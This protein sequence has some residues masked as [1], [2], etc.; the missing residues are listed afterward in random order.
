MSVAP[1]QLLIAPLRA[2]V[3]L[4][5]LVAMTPPAPAQGPIRPPLPTPAPAAEPPTAAE[6]SA[7]IAALDA[8]A[9]LDE[10]ARTT[11]K[12][13]YTDAI[14]ELARAEEHAARAKAFAAAASEAP[15]LLETIRAE[16]AQPPPDAAPAAPEGATLAQLEQALAQASAD[17]AAARQREQE[18][19]A[20]VDRAATRRSTLP[21]QIA[22]AR[23]RLADLDA[24][25][26]A[27]A[28]PAAAEPDRARRALLLAQRHAAAREIEA[29]GAELAREDAQRDLVPARRD[30]A[31]RRSAQAEK[32]HGAWQVIVDRTRQAEAE[33]A[34]REAERQRR[35]DAARRH[36]ALAALA[37]SN[38]DLAAARSGPGGITAKISAA[39]AELRDTI[40]RLDTI[41]AQFKSIRRR[42][43]VTGV[44]AATGRV[45]QRQRASLPDPDGL[46]RREREL[47]DEASDASLRLFELDERRVGAGD[48]D[49]RVQEILAAVPPNQRDDAEPIARELVTAQRDLLDQSG[50][51][52]ATYVD[53]LEQLTGKTRQLSELTRDFKAAIEERILWVRSV[54]GSIGDGV[55]ATPA[56]VR[57]LL[58]PD[59]WR[60]ALASAREEIERRPRAIFGAVLI[61]CVAAAGIWSRRE[62]KRLAEMA[63]RVRT[64]SV[65]QALAALVHSVIIALP[66]PLALGA[67]GWVL[68]QPARQPDVAIAVGHALR[69]AARI[70]FPLMVIHTVLRPGGLCRAHLGWPEAGAALNRR[71]L[72]WFMAVI[73]PLAVIVVAMDRQDVSGLWSDGLGRMAFTAAMLAFAAFAALTLHPARPL[74]GHFMVHERGTWRYRLDRL[75]IGL[76][77]GSPIALVILSWLGYYYTAL[78]LERRLQWSI[79]L[80]V[81]VVL[82]YGILLR[83][84]FLARRRLAIEEARRR[85]ES[86]RAASPA[87]PGEVAELPPIEEER[88]DI[89]AIDSQTRRLLRLAVAATALIGVLSIWSEIA[90]ALRVLDRV[91]IW[92]RLAFT[93]LTEEAP[94]SLAPSGSAEGGTAA[95]PSPSPEAPAPAAGEVPLPSTLAGGATGDPDRAGGAATIVSLADVGLAILLV[96][97]TVAAVRNVPGLV[98]II[99]LQRLPLDSGARYA[100]STMIRY[101]ILIVGISLACGM[102]G[103]RWSSVKWL[104]AAL[105]FGLAFGLQEIFANFVSGL[106]ILVERPVRVG[107]TVTI[108]TVSGTVTRIRMRA[109]TIVDWD[110][111]EL[112][113][114][115]R[116]LITDQVIN[117]TLS[118]PTLRLAI[119]VSITYAT[120]VAKAEAVLLRVARAC[121]G[122]LADPPPQ[123]VVVRFGDSSVDLEL[124]VVIPSIEHMVSVRHVLHRAILTEFAAAGIEMPYPQRDLH[125]R[126]A[127]GLAEIVKKRE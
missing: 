108:G 94:P 44:T 38:A 100:M 114:P 61:L 70:L 87:P 19:A 91:Q 105:T 79:W 58:A 12:A 27:D 69:T 10:A 18:L 89:P 102:V 29:L 52:Y 3:L 88:I 62:L 73:I 36:E 1:L 126:S 115:N 20:E 99:I 41:T 71:H 25:V 5:A 54:S 43:S 101:T 78:D 75:V 34:A 53:R 15:A 111:K 119:P 48:V 93:P 49:T 125:I 95:A 30:I 97:L 40:A 33:R 83:W 112:I 106:I 123:A 16:L 23:Q 77:V 8:A 118:D 120:E 50:R 32:T 60:E 72:R 13:L 82:A 67:A 47:R 26:A 68:L 96:F 103:I 31:L 116:T 122:V 113:V 11:A 90:P 81:A 7:R 35:R 55:R 21:D 127:P 46:R 109:T 42:L 14:A 121:E 4:I 45:L 57:W 2:I 6:L 22:A 98:E 24:R 51:D 86:A 66:L 85:R 104:A 124:R 80:L 17:L 39:E 28:A 64:Q 9:D 63:T 84:L 92:P 107:D 37:G 117:W 74:V 59:A 110:R 76:V 65:G 56:A